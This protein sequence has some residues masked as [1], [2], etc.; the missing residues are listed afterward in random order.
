MNHNL[1]NVAFKKD[2]IEQSTERQFTLHLVS[3][4]H[5]LLPKTRDNFTQK[6]RVRN[7]NISQ[8][9]HVIF[10]IRNVYRIPQTLIKMFSPDSYDSFARRVS[11]LGGRLHSLRRPVFL[12]LVPPSSRFDPTSVCLCTHVPANVH[13]HA[14]HVPCDPRAR[15]VASVFPRFRRCL[16]T[17]HTPSRSAIYVRTY[18]HLRSI[19]AI[20]RELCENERGKKSGKSLG[21]I[22]R[23]I[24]R[25]IEIPVSLLF[26]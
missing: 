20:T 10:H 15:F 26:A 18:V 5:F 16:C 24:E 1:I 4:E 9:T 21:G 13:M 11:V 22:E 23:A 17:A 25:E 14:R 12:P 8:A 7:R 6:F 2:T 19:L 3:F